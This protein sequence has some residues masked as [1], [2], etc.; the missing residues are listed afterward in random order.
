MPDDEAEVAVEWSGAA[1]VSGPLAEVRR[2]GD[3]TLACDATVADVSEPRDCDRAE[4]GCAFI[5]VVFP[6][7]CAVVICKADALPRGDAL[8]V[9]EG[10][11]TRGIASWG[12][13][14]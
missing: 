4:S 13:A 3:S 9:S 8:P 14:N 11:R 1:R 6:V 7:E 12:T 10:R 5:G 2:E